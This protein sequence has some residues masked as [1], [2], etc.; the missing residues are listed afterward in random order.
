[1]QA[2]LRLLVGLGNP[3]SDYEKTRHNAGFWFCERLAEQLGIG[4]LNEARFRGRVAHVRADRAWLL[5]PQTYMNRSGQSVGELARFHRI[6]PAEILVVHDDLD[7]SPGV[8]RLKFGG[9][10]GGHNGVK[11]IAAHLGSP[12]FWRLRVGIGHPG[13]RNEVAHFVLKSPS[14]EERGAI[15]EGLGRALAAWPWLQIGDWN[16]AMQRLN[17]KPPHPSRYGEAQTM[18]F[19]RRNHES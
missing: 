15:D 13:D 11:D 12:D 17:Q 3:G 4:F 18:C 5:M 9:G 8:L 1:M 6:S 16:A 14:G 7:L 2:S 10:A 19:H